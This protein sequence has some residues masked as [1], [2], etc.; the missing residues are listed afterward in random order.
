MS[1]PEKESTP[2]SR[3]VPA[4][5]ARELA[6][7]VEA[8]Y[9]GYRERFRAI[10]RRAR[11]RFERRDWEGTQ[12]DAAERLLLYKHIVDETVAAL[13]ERVRPG[14]DPSLR[15]ELKRE[16]AIATHGW[17]DVELAAT[18]YNSVV[19][20]VFEVVGVDPSGEFLDPADEHDDDALALPDHCE[21]S[22]TQA[23]PTLFRELLE[24]FGFHAAFAD[25]ERDARV[26]AA[27][28]AAH[29][30]RSHPGR[31]VRGVEM[32]RAPFFRN[33]AAYLVGRIRV[34]GDAVP[35]VLALL[36]ESEGIRVDAVLLEPD[37]A[38][39]VFGFTRSYFQVELE[40]PRAVVSFL[41][42]I[43]PLKRVHELY[44]G[45]GYHKHG[46]RELYYELKGHLRDPDARFEPA[47][48]KRGLV[49]I[50]FVLPS[51]NVVFKVIR[52][53][54]GPT[55]EGSRRDVMERYR[56][57]FLHDRVGRLA[58]A[59]QFE[60]MRFRR[61]CFAPEVLD[62]LLAEA[63]SVTRVD[64]D[65]VVIAH[66][67]TERRV[68]PLDIFL[69][70]A[71]ED[72]ARAAVIEYGNAIRDLAAAN[73]FPGDMLLKNFGVTRH[74]RVIFYD[75][76][77]LRLLTEVRFRRMPPPRDDADEMSAEPY[78]HVGPTDVFPEE[79]LPF[80]IPS[81]PLR[82]AFV[83]RHA[84]ILTCDFWQRMQRR[85]EARELV[86]FFPYPDAARLPRDEV[87]HSDP[88]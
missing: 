19:R 9:L 86:D 60:H 66:L 83:E 57:V 53:G 25:A 1:D 11:T 55:K 74:G 36:H 31:P 56:M 10:T 73:I 52:D 48:G 80:L 30:K 32:L 65:D 3:A 33:K 70:E 61:A 84:E 17:A 22:A 76:D 15:A 45:V 24:H 28:V 26:V 21:F 87:A 42:S 35:L 69:R 41:R 12:W 71:D 47:P 50:V 78:F 20:R 16:F 8:A 38:S 77:E 81:G 54:F 46:K 34:G 4:A 23:D 43:M 49:M 5:D 2:Q 62:E 44:T 29:L 7:A 18:F 85:Q 40:R 68:T 88:A 6:G 39:G 51:L 64:G 79:F 82:D 59:Q 75:Y 37:L 14:D 67:Y 63:G 58:D 27:R 13:R 72:H